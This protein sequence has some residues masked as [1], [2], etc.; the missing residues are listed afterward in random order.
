MSR[1]VSKVPYVHPSLIKAVGKH[2]RGVI[3]TYARSSVI[4][5][6]FIGKTFGVYNGKMHIPVYV[7]EHMIGHKLGE[8]SPTRV[9]KGHSGDKKASQRGGK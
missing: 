3:K 1:S 2:E 4:L 6:S 9:F 7:S 8:F 5:P